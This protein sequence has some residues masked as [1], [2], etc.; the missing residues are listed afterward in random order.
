MGEDH[1]FVKWDLENSRRLNNLRIKN[2]PSP[3]RRDYDWPGKFA[4][5]AHQRETAEFLTLNN[6]SFCFSEQ[7]TG[8]TAA[9][10]WAADYLMNIGDVTRVLI[11]CPV[12]VMQSAW[13]DDL[14]SLVMHRTTAIAHGTRKKREKVLAEDYDFVIINYD[15]LH[16]VETHLYNKFD[17]IIADE[18]NFVKTA[19]T[20][21]WKAFRRLVTPGTKLWLMTGTPAAQSPLDAYGIAKLVNPN[22]VP[23]YFGAWRDMVMI[24][25]SPWQWMPKKNATM[26]VNIALQPAIR[27]T[28]SECLDLPPVTYQTRTV[29][30]TPTQ[31]HCYEE[32][33]NEK[34]MRVEGGEGVSA[35]HAAAAMTKLLQVSCGAVYSD[36][37]DVVEVDC[38]NRLRE[39]VDIVNATTNKVVVFVPFRHAIT[40]LADRLKSEKISAEVVN[41]EVSA[42]KRAD[43]FHAFQTTD[44]PRVLVIQPQSAAH[45]IT[46]TAADTI[47]WFGPIASVETWLQANE[48]INRPPQKNKMTIIKI[49]GSPIEKRVYKALESKESQ[50]RMLTRI[51][52]EERDDSGH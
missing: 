11:V 25:T 49:C 33:K 37:G 43:I 8:K 32:I 1:V 50:H 22:L 17:L 36:S 4:P 42:Q 14:F 30:L 24:R 45:G 18:C 48:R 41:G 31:W 52:E 7:G 35:V 10:I 27:F 40:I 47:V 38:R 13:A 19:T 23:R 20:R 6:R 3:I 46:L 21:R 9:A 34:F 12:S 28:K 16:T 44:D 26:L 39:V 2:T 5:Y 29:N 15:G 51:Y